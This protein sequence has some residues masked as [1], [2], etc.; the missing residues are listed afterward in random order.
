[1]LLGILLVSKLLT[2]SL[3]YVCSKG[4]THNELIGLVSKWPDKEGLLCAAKEKT[5]ASLMSGVS[6]DRLKLASRNVNYITEVRK[7]IDILM[8]TAV[9]NSFSLYH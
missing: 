2:V 7:P 1:M 6:E 9:E 8:G 5:L 3:S 4:A